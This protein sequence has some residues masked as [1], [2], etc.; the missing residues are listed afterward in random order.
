MQIYFGV[1][2]DGAVFPDFPG[3]GQGAVD[4]SVVGPRGLLRALEIQLGLTGPI[5]N[6]AVRVAAYAKKIQSL[7][8]RGSCFFSESFDSDPWA[9]AQTLLAWRDDLIA[10]GW[11]RS[12]TGAKRIDDLASIENEGLVIPA[13]FADRLCLAIGSL[14]TS[15]KLALQE[16]HLVTPRELL[17]PQYQRLLIAL[18]ACN[19]AIIESKAYEGS[20]EG[21]LSRAQNFIST[22]KIEPLTADGTFVMLEA[23]TSLM[24]AE[25]IADWLASG[26]DDELSDTLVV[27]PDGDTALLDQAL[28]ARGLP[29][30]GQSAPSPWRGALQVLPMAFAASWAPFNANALLDLL[31]L[32]RPP[33]GKYAAHVLAYALSR[34]PGQGGGAW[35]RAW[36][37]IETNLQDR[38][39]DSD[40]AEKEIAERLKRWKEWTTPTSHRRTEGMP[41]SVARTI[42]GRV[43]NWAIQTDGGKGDPLLLSV[44]TAASAMGDAIE[45]LG[46][47]VLP[48]LTIDRLI[49]QVLAEGA[50]NPGHVATA[51]GLRSVAGP[52]AVWAPA[53][54]I[55]WWNFRGPGDRIRPAPWSKRELEALAS[56]GCTLESSAQQAARISWNYANVVKMAHERIIFVRPALSG[57]EETTSHPLA[58]QLQPLLIKPSSKISWRAE[59]L[60]DDASPTFAGRKL[61]REPI[62]VIQPPQVRGQWSLPET[63][64]S[65]LQDRKE[66]ATSFERLI[67]CQMRWLLIDVLRLSPG[68]FAEIP[69][70]DQLLGNLAHEIANQVFQ[71][72]VTPVSDI[73]RVQASDKFD[74]LVSA[75][76]APLLQPEF[77]A[78]LARA[79]V[80]VPQAL[81]H[82]SRILEKRGIELV[83]TELE[84]DMDFAD[85]LSVTGRL[86]MV[87]RHPSDGVG[88][89][90]LKWTKSDKRRRAELKDGNAIQLATYG[91]IADGSETSAVTGAY[92][93]LNQRR[94]I[95]PTGSFLA[96]DEIEPTRS[97]SDT[98]DAVVATWKGWR[99]LAQQGI[100]VAAGVEGAEAHF[101]SDL[102]FEAKKEPCTYCEMTGLCRVAAENN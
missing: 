83:G 65:K 81:A 58:H 97:L 85:G 42:A 36:A 73:V 66:S 94:L 43:G 95:A 19:V 77:A 54:R 24:A 52:D 4:A 72:G 38:F 46:Q 48:A 86:D 93:L 88:V 37:K 91:A 62:S 31:L 96:D 14:R 99:D 56:A 47:D 39:K 67:D 21:D 5:S 40:V 10:A 20:R 16:V 32:P 45:M 7:S 26:T 101:P 1:G 44:A 11:D 64:A 87:V 59:T 98:W 53:R 27:D 9:T 51:G 76:A 23:D 29:L 68:R 79:K 3:Q 82:L 100:A 33:I 50:T 6:E 15:P 92:Y 17:P 2:C 60:L 49:E 80:K 61:A 89:V 70:A 71:A 12:P 63:I 30:L 25:A 8:S 74:D 28:A 102:G 57:N 55:I 13:G 35:T 34:E 90:D 69:G 84:R 78:E 18:E 22:G 41:A 75:I